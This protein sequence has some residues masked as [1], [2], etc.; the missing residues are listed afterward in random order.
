MTTHAPDPT[1]LD[2]RAALEA[3][4]NGIYGAFA[5]GD[6]PAILDTLAPDVSWEEWPDNS[7]HDD[8]AV[9]YLVPRHGAAGVAE[10]FGLLATFTF[11]D[12]QVRS[13]FAGESEAVARIIAEWSLPNGGRVRDE[14]IHWWQFDDAGRVVAFRHYLDTAK[15]RAA[16]AGEDT[17]RRSG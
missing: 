4:I 11:H 13:V 1:A 6:L 17:T 3:T 16:A 8:P 7:V 2:R 5:R 14:E 12:F 10:F 9:P 15:H